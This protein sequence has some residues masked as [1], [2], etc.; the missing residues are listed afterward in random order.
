MSAVIKT[1]I[2]HTLLMILLSMN[3]VVVFSAERGLPNPVPDHAPL[4]EKIAFLRLTEGFWQVWMMNTDGSMQEQLTTTLVDKVHMVWGPKNQRLLYNTNQGQTRILDLGTRKEKRILN[5]HKII[6]AAWSPDGKTLAYGLSP[7]NL[8]HGKTSL[9]VSDLKGG[10]RSK[11]AGGQKTDALAP[12]WSRDG[13]QLV[14]RQCM[15]VNNMQVYHDFWVSDAAGGHRHLI[16]GD[17]EMLK[18]D[19]VVSRQGVLAYSSA[20]SGFYEIWT[21]PVKGGQRHQ[22][23]RFQQYAGDPSWSPDGQSLV[24]DSDKNGRQQIYRIRVNGKQLVALTHDKPPSR[25]PVWSGAAP[26]TGKQ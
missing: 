26:E 25:K 10:Q 5:G 20:R 6:D 7:K 4:T 12:M 18:F 2:N 11:M 9:W 23:T 17:H 15:M 3:S 8:A 14:F 22:L 19:Q 16:D 13:K 21:L 24:F 1:I